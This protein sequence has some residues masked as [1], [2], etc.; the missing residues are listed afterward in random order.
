MKVNKFITTISMY[1]IL[2]SFLKE[3]S[4][5]LSQPVAGPNKVCGIVTLLTFICHRVGLF[6]QSVVSMLQETHQ[7]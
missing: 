3:E 2:C 7:W 4:F 1:V 6:W 5:K